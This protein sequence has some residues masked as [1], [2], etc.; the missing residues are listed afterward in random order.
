MVDIKT[1][2]QL[3]LVEKMLK[4]KVEEY[5]KIYWDYEAILDKTKTEK[6][7]NE[8]AFGHGH[9]HWKDFEKYYEGVVAVINKMKYDAGVLRDRIL[10]DVSVPVR[11]VGA[12]KKPK[13]TKPDEY[14]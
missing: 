7:K 9:N 13:Y 14:V 3:D 11:D 1:Y 5:N 2:M 8:I 4:E 6:E 10:Q 12:G